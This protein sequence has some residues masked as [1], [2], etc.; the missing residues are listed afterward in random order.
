MFSYQD[1]IPLV[2]GDYDISVI[3]RNRV[4]YQYTVAEA[5]V[6]VEAITPAM[7]DVV[8]GFSFEESAASDT[9]TAFETFAVAGTRIHPATDGLFA[10]GD[11]AYVFL[12]VENQQPDHRL[13][14]SL[15]SFV[16]GE[17]VLQE[18]TIPAADLVTQSVIRF[19]SLAGIVGG[20]YEV[21]SELLDATGSV[22]VEKSAPIVVSPRTSVPRP[23]FTARRS[24]DPAEPGLL[25]MTVGDQLWS[26]GRRDY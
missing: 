16:G 26:L 4:Q 14:I 17:T 25:A 18:Q 2:P 11:T 24:F 1:G 9:A 5:H 21:R 7:S 3:L 6:R 22:L 13:R 15:V 10:I 8:L 20:N 23:A 12:Q 19:L